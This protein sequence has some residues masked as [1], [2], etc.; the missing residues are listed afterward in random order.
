M[1]PVFPALGVPLPAFSAAPATIAKASIAAG[2]T[3][4]TTFDPLTRYVSF[5]IFSCYC[6]FADNPCARTKEQDGRTQNFFQ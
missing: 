1:A 3:L 6:C 5:I 4:R 2:I